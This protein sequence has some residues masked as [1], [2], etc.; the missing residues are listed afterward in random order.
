MGLVCA[1]QL[2]LGKT[3]FAAIELSLNDD[4]TTAQ[5]ATSKRQ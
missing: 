1:L 2:M 5:P 3:L 4:I